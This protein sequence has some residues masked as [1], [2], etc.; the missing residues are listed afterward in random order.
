M[1]APGAL[2]NELAVW[3]I[4][5]LF[6]AAIWAVFHYFLYGPGAGVMTLADDAA[7]RIAELEFE[8]M[9]L[10]MYGNKS[11]TAMADDQIEKK[12]SGLK[13]DFED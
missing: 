7:A 8:V 11:C 4:S 1:S 5:G 2:E 12:R 13:C 3:I 10:R 6:G 9:V